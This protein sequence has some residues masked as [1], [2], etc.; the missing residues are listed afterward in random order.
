MG[1]FSHDF[2]HV[3]KCSR[4]VFSRFEARLPGEREAKNA[5]IGHFSRDYG[6]DIR[7]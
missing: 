6:G 7:T 2:N 1:D 4:L 3:I 5:K